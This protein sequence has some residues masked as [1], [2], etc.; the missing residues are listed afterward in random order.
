MQTL[1]V[2]C[3]SLD[4]RAPLMMGTAATFVGSTRYLLGKVHEA[5][6]LP[7]LRRETLLTLVRAPYVATENRALPVAQASPARRAHGDDWRTWVGDHVR[8]SDAEWVDA[9]RG[10]W[11]GAIETVLDLGLLAIGVG[12]F[13]TGLLRITGA[14]DVGSAKTNMHRFD[15]ELLA[16][17]SGPLGCLPRLGSPS[18]GFSEQERYLA[19]ALPGARFTP[20]SGPSIGLI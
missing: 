12:G 11:N 17:L 10:D 20:V 1:A 13:I 19:Q 16:R 15:A 4:D 6:Y 18:G 14:H 9:V 2:R 3:E 5:G 7:D 8:L